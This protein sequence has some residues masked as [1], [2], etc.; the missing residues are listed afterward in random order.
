MCIWMCSNELHDC[1]F[2]HMACLMVGRAKR[3][4]REPGAR[5]VTKRTG[6]IQTL[7]ICGTIAIGAL[8]IAPSVAEAQSRGS[9][10]VNANVVQTD[11]AFRALEAARVAVRTGTTIEAGRSISGAPTVA[12]V[13]TVREQRAV[14]V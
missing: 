14:V 1:T 10:Q 3:S 9:L 4:Q 7:V 12:R 13:A 5:T 6:M 11:N 2:G 8:G